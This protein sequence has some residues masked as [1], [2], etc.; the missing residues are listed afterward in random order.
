MRNKE[1]MNIKA[2]GLDINIYG[3]IMMELLGMVVQDYEYNIM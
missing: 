1:N 2:V 3:N